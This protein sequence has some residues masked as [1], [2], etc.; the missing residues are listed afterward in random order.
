[1]M[2]LGS[3][4]LVVLDARFIWPQGQTG[5]SFTGVEAGSQA[6]QA[7]QMPSGSH[8]VSLVSL[9]FVLFNGSY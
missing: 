4:R 1:M 2:R 3:W 5:Q 6:E 9:T 7:P 8:K